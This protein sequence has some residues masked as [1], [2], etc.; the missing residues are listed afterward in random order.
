IYNLSGTPGSTLATA[1]IN[2]K[3]RGVKVR[4]ICEYD[5]VNSTFNSL[6]SAGIPLINDRFDAINNG[7]GLMHNKF[8]VIDGRSGAPESSWVWTGSW[9]P[10][11]PGTN[12]DFQNAIEI[13]D[14]ALANAYTLEF[15]E[16]WGSTTDTPNA[17][18]SHFGARKLD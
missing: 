11:D 16:M 2:A 13:Q 9:N 14:Q 4:I 12:D 15:D 1:L 6:S 3:N 7:A 18:A 10:T 5:N 8:F 17:S